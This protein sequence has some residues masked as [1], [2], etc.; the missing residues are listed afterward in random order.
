MLRL[1]RQKYIIGV[2]CLAHTFHVKPSCKGHV[3]PRR[4]TFV[5]QDGTWLSPGSY[6]IY[7]TLTSRWS[8]N[9][10]LF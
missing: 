1:Q 10:K 4:A 3:G 7:I 5:I 2:L 9:F 8:E 6:G